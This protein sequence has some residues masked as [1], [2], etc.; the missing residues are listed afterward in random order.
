MRILQILG[1]SHQADH[2][3]SHGISPPKWEFE[4]FIDLGVSHQTEYFLFHSLSP[5]NRNGNLRFLQL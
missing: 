4:I 3:H 2:F 5:L 1:I